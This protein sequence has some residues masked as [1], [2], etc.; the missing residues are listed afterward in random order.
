MK[1]GELYNGDKIVKVFKVP[2]WFMR[3]VNVPLNRLLKHLKVN[4]VM[5]THTRKEIEE[6][7]AEMTGVVDRQEMSFIKTYFGN[8]KEAVWTKYG[9][10][11]PEARDFDAMVYDP[12]NYLIYAVD[13][14][15]EK[16]IVTTDKV[17]QPLKEEAKK[18]G[19]DKGEDK[20]IENLETNK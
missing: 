2:K 16:E 18:K 11:N 8:L 20:T 5:T 19:N 9:L 10:M 14:K 4:M 3:E 12:D 15:E 17:V 1:Q 7:V 6:F 13:E